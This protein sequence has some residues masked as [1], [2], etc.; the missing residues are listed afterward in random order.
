MKRSD[1]LPST[2]VDAGKMLPSPYGAILSL[3]RVTDE[4]HHVINSG[5]RYS[6]HWR[7]SRGCASVSTP[8]PGSPCGNSA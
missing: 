3:L 6:A 4:I 5:G 2:C 7:V 8:P 1:P